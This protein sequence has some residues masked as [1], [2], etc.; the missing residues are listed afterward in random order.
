MK[1]REPLGDRTL[2]EPPIWNEEG[3]RERGEW[4]KSGMDEGRSNGPRRQEG[5]SGG[6]R[7]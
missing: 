7:R 4:T 1:E 3:E 6:K 5:R 2:P